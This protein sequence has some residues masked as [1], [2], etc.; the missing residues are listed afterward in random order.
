M[1]QN[2]LVVMYTLEKLAYALVAAVNI[3]ACLCCLLSL[4]F[5]YLNLCDGDQ[6]TYYYC[7]PFSWLDQK[8]GEDAEIGLFQT[9]LLQKV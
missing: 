6:K 5:P 2:N 8:R 7:L 9:D 1:C 3:I 4:R